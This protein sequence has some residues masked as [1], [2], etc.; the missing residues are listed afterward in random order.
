MHSS[1]PLQL[2][3][4]QVRL[5]PAFMVGCMALGCP[6]L[7][8]RSRPLSRLREAARACPS[9]PKFPPDPAWREI[10]YPQH[11]Q[12]VSVQREF[13]PL[14]YRAGTACKVPRGSPCIDE[15]QAACSRAF[16][17][18][19]PLLDL[20]AE[21]AP[22]PSPCKLACVVCGSVMAFACEPEFE[23]ALAAVE[24]HEAE[25]LETRVEVLEGMR[26]LAL[27][28][29]RMAADLER[30]FARRLRGLGMAWLPRWRR[31]A[32]LRCAKRAA[33]GCLVPLAAE[34]CR[35]HGRRA[36]SLK[37][38]AERAEDKRR[39]PEAEPPAMPPSKTIASP[40]KTAARPTTMSKASW[41]GGARTSVYVP[42]Q[43]PPP[44][45]PRPPPR[46]PDPR[47]LA[48]AAGCARLD[49][50]QQAG[51]APAAAAKPSAARKRDHRLGGLGR[52]EAAGARRDREPAQG[53]GPGA[54]R[55]AHAPPLLLPE[56]APGRVRP[57]PARLPAQERRGHVPLLRR[58]RG[59]RDVGRQRDHGR[60]PARAP[61]LR[62]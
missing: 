40:S 42:P 36:P 49:K 47:L 45:K 37:R 25:A 30:R 11:M 54:A 8:K 43:G 20:A 58:L 7:P 1:V 26:G 6:G 55:P 9:L 3:N 2:M 50:Q 4:R 5:V 32:H 15:D 48:A 33:C 61:V 60:R 14:C 46:K 52:P 62:V 27:L 38:P 57:V 16:P 21:G 18:G 31:L 59:P 17:G 19:L 35:T 24:E 53:A 34:A 29:E 13:C 51:P 28:G 56:A 41:L 22:C 12:R 39:E 23:L 44:I 10:K